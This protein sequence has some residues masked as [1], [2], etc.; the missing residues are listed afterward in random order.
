MRRQVFPFPIQAFEDNLTPWEFKV[1]VWLYRRA[2]RDLRCWPSMRDMLV[3][4]GFTENTV[5][6]ALKVLWENGWIKKR[7]QRH[8]RSTILTLGVPAKFMSWHP[9]DGGQANGKS[10]LKLRNHK[11]PCDGGQKAGLD[12]HAKGVRR[13]LHNSEHA[14]G[15][16]PSVIIQPA[17]HEPNPFND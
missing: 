6:D 13:S 2:N 7:E 11:T 8:R 12:P 5:T 15:H 17:D 16:D 3:G 4:T 9:R 14:N 10:C 1:L